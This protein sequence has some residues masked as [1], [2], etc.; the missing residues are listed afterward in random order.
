M[1]KNKSKQLA[2]SAGSYKVFQP[3][4][5]KKIDWEEARR[6]IQFV[7]LASGCNDINPIIDSF[8]KI[9]GT[10]D[11]NPSVVDEVSKR[12][13]L[14]KRETV[15]ALIFYRD[16]CGDRVEILHLLYGER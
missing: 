7:T 12:T 15:K 4:P 16:E 14:S 10:F 3:E 8:C 6:R 13:G 5:A 2:R 9:L 11:S 1:S